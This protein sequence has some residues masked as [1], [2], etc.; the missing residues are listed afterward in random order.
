MLYCVYNCRKDFNIMKFIDTFKTKGLLDLGKS[1]WVTIEPCIINNCE[2]NAGTLVIDASVCEFED[3]T[4]NNI[5]AGDLILVQ[6]RTTSFYDYDDLCTGDL[7]PIDNRVRS[8]DTLDSVNFDSIY[9]NFNG[10]VMLYDVVNDIGKNNLY[11]FDICHSTVNLLTNGD[12]LLNFLN[13]D[14]Y[15]NLSDIGSFCYSET[16]KYG[17]NHDTKYTSVDG[18]KGLY[19]K[20]DY[21][22]ND[23][24]EYTSFA[25][26]WITKNDI[27]A[28]N[29][30]SKYGV[31]V[32]TDSNDVYKLSD[33][34]LDSLKVINA[35]HERNYITKGADYDTGINVGDFNLS[36]DSFKNIYDTMLS[37]DNDIP[38]KCNYI[39][40]S[41]E[42]N[43][44]AGEDY[45]S[46]SVMF[47]IYFSKDTLPCGL[48]VEP[49]NMVFDDA[50]GKETDGFNTV[51]KEFISY[52]DVKGFVLKDVDVASDDYPKGSSGCDYKGDIVL[53]DGSI[54]ENVTTSFDLYSS[55][56]IAAYMRSMALLSRSYRRYGDN[57]DVNKLRQ[58]LAIVPDL[59]GNAISA[60]LEYKQSDGID[61]STDIN[62]FKLVQV[63]GKDSKLVSNVDKQTYIT[64]VPEVT[65]SDVSDDKCVE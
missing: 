40:D 25:L 14:G 59:G 39:R 55:G 42:F 28:F 35:I 56:N 27:D 44:D 5:K 30:C 15:N 46:R 43:E 2:V 34:I 58:D 26:E 48:K 65:K 49:F 52:E 19:F 16:D 60:Y 9:H 1:M 11:T 63:E 8:C 10:D 21:V 38:C 7:L 37:V 64:D 33:P 50:F 23:N 6:N 57:I 41:Y 32:S 36:I 17:K 53:A 61:L 29:K 12:K 45:Y 31:F 4:A 24:T 18:I 62:K 20:C 3:D 51:D 47:N 22:S 54:V 13:T